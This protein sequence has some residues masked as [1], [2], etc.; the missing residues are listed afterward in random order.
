MYFFKSSD[1]SN[2]IISAIISHRHY[3]KKRESPGTCGFKLSETTVYSYRAGSRMLCFYSLWWWRSTVTGEITGARSPPHPTPGHTRWE[4]ERKRD[5]QLWSS[6]QAGARALQAHLIIWR[7]SFFIRPKP[8]DMLK[9]VLTDLLDPV[10]SPRGVNRSE[11]TEKDLNENFILV[12]IIYL[13]SM[14]QKKI[15]NKNFHKRKNIAFMEM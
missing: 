8:G 14:S 10:W 13:Y 3:M 6:S 5:T 9:S 12:L 15:R 7:S 1:K 4:M 2:L 11:E